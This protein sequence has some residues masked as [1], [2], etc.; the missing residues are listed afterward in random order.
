MKANTYVKLGRRRKEAE[1][2]INIDRVSDP[3]RNKKMKTF[4]E[5]VEAY[6]SEMRKEDNV[7]TNKELKKTPEGKKSSQSLSSSK[8]ETKQTTSWKDWGKRTY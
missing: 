7:K 1:R 2:N 4:K 5:F 3:S 8:P 6:F